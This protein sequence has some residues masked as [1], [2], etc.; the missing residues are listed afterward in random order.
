MSIF[1]KKSFASSGA[2]NSPSLRPERLER[3]LMYPSSGQASQLAFLSLSC[4]ELNLRY[5]LRPQHSF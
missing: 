5:R 4:A 2:F 1:R 3:I